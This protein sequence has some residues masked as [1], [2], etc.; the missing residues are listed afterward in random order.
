[1][2]TREHLLRLLAD[3][4][5]HSGTE[6][7]GVLALT[8]GGVWKALQGLAEW[9]VEV[10][11]RRG[12]GYRL[13]APLELLDHD[14]IVAALGEFSHT[15]L[16]SLELHWSLGSTNDHLLELSPA[17]A[18]RARACLAEFQTRGRG[19]RG[20]VWLAPLGDSLCL[21]LAWCFARTP[22]SLSS[23]G[24]VAGVA[25]RRALRNSGVPAELKWP[26][27][28]VLDGRKLA[29]I[30]VDVRGESGG[31]LVAVVGV[32][33]NVRCREQVAAAINAAG[34]LQPAAVSEVVPAAV[35]SRNELA[36]HLLDALCACMQVYT[37]R[38]FAPFAA[39]W[40][41]ADALAGRAVTVQEGQ[42]QI[43]GIARGIS[44][45]GQLLLDTPQGLQHLL[46]GD[47]R[48]RLDT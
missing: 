19:R 11:A 30:L 21:S 26:N 8:R 43:Q 39:E 44:D 17:S 9:G 25:V 31:P 13:K 18:G 4:E 48:V 3:G 10:E 1:M 7:A 46:T 5:L 23:L 12:H 34:G 45:D 22:A 38:G 35:L 41:A 24:L 47:V 33:V 42:R 14:R 2:D 37:E 28:L 29:G 32:G 6:L 27:D 40:G 16:E 36:A 20:R 15:A